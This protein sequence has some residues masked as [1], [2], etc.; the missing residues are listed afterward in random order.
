M[1]RLAALAILA[2]LV[3]GC[4]GGDGGGAGTSPP[5]S[6]SATGT[7]TSG[8]GTPVPTAVQNLDLLLTFS[9]EHCEGIG[10]QHTRALDDVQALLP[11][12]FVAA[13]PPDAPSTAPGAEVGV[14]ALDLYHCGNLTTS[15]KA[16]PDTYVGWLYT[17]IQRPTDRVPQAPDAPVQEYVFRM[18]A[19]TDILATLWPAAG[20]DTFSGQ[21]NMSAVSVTDGLPLPAPTRQGSI[22]ETRDPQ[23]ESYLVTATGAGLAALE[24]PRTQAFAR[25]NVIAADGSVLLWTGTYDLPSVA[26]GPGSLLMPPGDPFER[27]APPG[28]N[29]LAG[30]AHQVE[31]GGVKAQDLRRIFV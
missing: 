25:Y 23:G 4:N 28:K 21:A 29:T 15:A 30:V 1:T 5:T 2:L 24:Q 27:F 17:Y 22:G 3:A 18:L 31:D 20:Y 13:P 11:D 12:G 16:V 6:T 10:F 19:G 8:T 9:F 26:T 7:S 14:L